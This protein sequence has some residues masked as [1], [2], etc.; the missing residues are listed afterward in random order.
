MNLRITEEEYRRILAA[1]PPGQKFC[2]QC[3][4]SKSVRAF[5]RDA[6]RPDGRFPWCRVCRSKRRP[7]ADCLTDDFSKL[8]GWCDGPIGGTHANREFCSERCKARARGLAQYSLTVAEYRLLMEST[9]GKCSICARH[10]KR[11][12][13][14]HNHTT[15]EVLGPVCITCNTTLLTFS[16]HDP[17]VA[18]RL[19]EFLESPPVR[20]FFGERYATER[21]NKAGEYARQWR[22][23]NGR[24]GVWTIATKKTAEASRDE[25]ENEYEPEHVSF[26]TKLGG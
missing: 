17:D 20:R 23:R 14:D 19:V 22:G 8:C 12:N 2:W 11:W 10:T 7:T 1:V 3:R 5:D 16:Y 21:L 13:L 6:S 18:R 25:A 24:K 4:Y 26:D 15:G 9:G